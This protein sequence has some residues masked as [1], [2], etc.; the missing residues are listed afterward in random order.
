[1]QL[2]YMV[3]E[4]Y[5][6]H[7]GKDVKD[8]RRWAYEIHSSFLVDKAVSSALFFTNFALS[9][10]LQVTEHTVTDSLVSLIWLLNV[11]LVGELSQSIVFFRGMPDL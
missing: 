2:F 9:V 7:A 6:I 8:M 1:M 5:F 10:V 11:F 4:P 3:T